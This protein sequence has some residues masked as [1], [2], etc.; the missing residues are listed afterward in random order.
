MSLLFARSQRDR[1]EAPKYWPHPQLREL[2]K[3]VPASRLALPWVSPSMPWWELQGPWA[4]PGAGGGKLLIFTRLKAVPPALASLL[5]FDLEASFA[6]RLRHNYRRAGEAKP[7]QFK[8]DR[9][10]LPALFFP[11][12]TLIAF[13]DPRRDKPSN[14]AEVRSS[15]RRQIGQFLRER[16]NSGGAQ[17]WRRNAHSGSSCLPSNMLA[18]AYS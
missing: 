11:S 9:P 17:E 13:T 7:L 5:S 8:E 2:N 14:L 15:M 4:A 6:H 3:I 10:T 18:H 16:L 1:L 12:P